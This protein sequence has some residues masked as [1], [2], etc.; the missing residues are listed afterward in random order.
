MRVALLRCFS[1]AHLLAGGGEV[2]FDARLVAIPDQVVHRAQRVLHRPFIAHR[3][4]AVCQSFQI[5]YQVIVISAGG[6]GTS[7]PLK[8]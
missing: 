4:K 3:G 6:H 2:A 5:G 7:S 1:L 8:L